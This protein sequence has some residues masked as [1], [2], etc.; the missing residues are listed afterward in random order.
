M[1]LVKDILINQKVSAKDGDIIV[2]ESDAQHIEHILI[3]NTGQ[4]YQFPTLGVGV[5]DNIKGTINQQSFKQRIKRNLESDNYRVKDLKITK[6][7]EEL[8]TSIDTLRLR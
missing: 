4:F 5:I 7:L 8:I 3:A 2:G 6:E 1:E